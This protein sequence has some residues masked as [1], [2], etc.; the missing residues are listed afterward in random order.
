MKSAI[1]S[2]KWIYV[3]LAT[4]R[5][6]NAFAIGKSIGFEW[7]CKCDSKPGLKTEVCTNAT[8]AMK[9][10]SKIAA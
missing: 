10:K 2:I 5:Y 3:D 4:S 9:R 8:K 7:K 6:F 1:G